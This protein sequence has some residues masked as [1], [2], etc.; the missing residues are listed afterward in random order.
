MIYG[1]LRKSNEEG[2]NSSFDTQKYKIECYCNLHN[3]KVDEWFE[4]IC[5]GGTLINRT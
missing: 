4:D 3:L 2:V 5:S 1:Y